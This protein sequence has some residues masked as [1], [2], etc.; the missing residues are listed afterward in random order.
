MSVAFCSAPAA[1]WVRHGTALHFSARLPV[2]SVLNLAEL[3]R[4]AYLLRQ[5]LDLGAGMEQ[6]RNSAEPVEVNASTRV[7]SIR[8]AAVTERSRTGHLSGGI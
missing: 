8:S 2:C 1:F 4:H 3:L 6:I 5:V 7:K